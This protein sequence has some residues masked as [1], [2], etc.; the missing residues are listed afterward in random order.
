MTEQIKEVEIKDESTVIF[1]EIDKMAAK[2]KIKINKLI[3]EGPHTKEILGCI[4]SENINLMVTEFQKDTLLKY[5]IFYESPVPVWLEHN[6]KKLKKIY[7]ILTNLSPNKLA[8]KAAFNLS[9]KMDL[10]L[11]FYYVLDESEP[12]NEKDEE[13][14]RRYLEKSLERMKQKTNKGFEYDIV[15]Q[16]ISNF[17]VQHFKRDKSSLVILGRFTKPVKLPFI[18]L[19]KKIEASKKISASV[20]LLK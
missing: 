16:D 4:K 10:P 14:K 9:K 12:Y 18:S 2:K 1:N 11:K 7:G 8:P 5:R 19:D 17:I 13:K 3:H 15:Q 6:G 20:L